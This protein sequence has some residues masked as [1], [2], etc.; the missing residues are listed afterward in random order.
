MDTLDEEQFLEIDSWLD[1]FQSRMRDVQE[2]AS[3]LTEGLAGSSATKSSPDGAVTV[4]V[5]ANGALLKLEFG[6]RVGE[7]APPQL[8]A[9]VMRTVREAQ[10]GASEKVGEALQ[11]F[12]DDGAILAQY[13]NF[14]PPPPEEPPVGPP[15]GRP[16]NQQ[17]PSAFAPPPAP[18]P[19]APPKPPAAGPPPAAPQSPPP[20]SRRPRG[21]R[22][23]DDDLAPW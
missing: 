15:P 13:K 10:R 8:A 3:K 7:H 21:T 16:Q 12:G 9:L 22:D 18:D 19:V 20:P 6:R 1:N 23:D 5:G 4:T 2:K 14:Q 17:A 11:E